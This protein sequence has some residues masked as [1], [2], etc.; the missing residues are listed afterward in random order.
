MSDFQQPDLD[1]MRHSAAHIMAAAIQSL[2][3]TAKFGVGPTTEHGFYYDVLVDTAISAEDLQRIEDKMK[4]I[5]KAKVMIEREEWPID[6]AIEYMREHKQDFKVELL[7]LLKSKGSTAVAE[8]TGDKGLVA[9][10]ENAGV[11]SVSFYKLGDFVDLCRG[12]HVNRTDK[13]G[14]LKLMSVAGAYWRGKSENPQLQRIY[15]FCYETKEELDK[16]IWQQEEAEKRDHRK[17]GREL[18]LFHMQEEAA[19][20]VFW[21]SRG[22]TL[23]RLLENFIRQRISK[24]GYVEVNTPQLVDSSL[25]KASGH[26]DFYGDNMFKVQVEEERVFGLKPMNCPCHVQIFKSELKSYRELPLR[27][28]EFGSCMRNEASGAMHGIMRVRAM[29]QDDAH[30]FC[31]EDQIESESLKYFKLQLGIYEVLGFGGNNIKVK[32]AL[33]PDKRAG[34]DEL[35]DKAEDGL[36]HALRGAGLEF[37]EVPND[38]A[39]YGPKVEF[40][41]TDAIGRS[42]QCGTLQ[43]DFVLPERLGAEY[44]GED[45]QRHAPVM[46]HRAALGSLERFIGILIE[47]H[48]GAFPVWLSPV[49]ARIIPIADRHIDYANKVQHMLS[50]CDIPLTIEGIRADVDA[51]AERMQKKIR[52]AQLEKIPYMLV[53]GDREAETESVSVRLR[54]GTDLGSIPL[55][56][57]IERITTECTTRKDMEAEAVISAA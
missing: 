29:T 7:E 40:H 2:W 27:M 28:A 33:R 56:Q 46:L 34:R 26:W 1:T 21:H 39:F 51:S 31:R 38:G 5:I 19:G 30:I 37:T 4:Q 10:S 24:D 41:L 6:K 32:L 18:K 52:E 36:R 43:L 15:G 25:Y 44:I 16:A 42:W 54:N 55:A 11:S 35:W 49:Q 50:E 20:Q 57:F 45:S 53:V 22:W 23:F 17:L 14:A 13:V 9:E 48:A 47:H 8:E 12:P 3:P